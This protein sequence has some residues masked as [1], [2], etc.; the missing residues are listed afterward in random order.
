MSRKMPKR[1]QIKKKKPARKTNTGSTSYTKKT[2]NKVTRGGNT[3]VRSGPSASR[4]KKP[5]GG[6]Y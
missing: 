2:T 3:S 4:G 5:K 1:L 6:G